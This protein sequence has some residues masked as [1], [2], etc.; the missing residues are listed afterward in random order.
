MLIGFYLLLMLSVGRSTDDQTFVTTTARVGENVTLTCS[1]DKSKQAY[2][3]FWIRLVAGNLPEFFGKTYNFKYNDENRISRIQ[4][5]HEP[6]TFVLQITETTQSD[7]AFYYCFKSQKCNIAFLKG[8]FL[9]I[10]EPEPDITAVIQ[11]SPSDPVRPGDSVTLQCSVLSDSKK[12]TCPEQQHSV[13]WFKVGS[14]QSHPSLVYSQTNSGDECEK[15]P[16][17]QSPHSCVYS[18]LKDNVSSSDAGTYYCALAACGKVVFG[19]GT[20]LD[21]EGVNTHDSQK[22][23]TFLFVLCAALATSLI[24]IVFLVCA[25]RKNSCKASVALQPNAETVSDLQQNQQRNQ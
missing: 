10:E 4:T 9:R 6:G 12:K 22:V 5:K 18:F 21:I 16:E 14:D 19:N 15:S 11:H 17:A 23:D 25:I 8:I 7:T 3:L 13:F 24:V 20:K 1:H 2:A